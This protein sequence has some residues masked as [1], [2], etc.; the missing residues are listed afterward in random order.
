PANE[1]RPGTGPLT[2]PGARPGT[3]PLGEGAS[4][5]TGTTGKLNLPS[6]G[7]GSSG[8]TGTAPLQWPKDK[9]E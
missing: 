7:G 5:R 6:R 3:G 2:P 4:R 1:P 9:E 8:R